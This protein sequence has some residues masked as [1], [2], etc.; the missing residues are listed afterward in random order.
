M[1]IYLDDI[2]TPSDPFW[3]VVRKPAAF[4]ELMLSLKDTSKLEVSFDHDLADDHYEIYHLYE[5]TPVIE[6]VSET[7][8]DLAKWM[9]DNNIIPKTVWVHSANPAGAKNIINLFENR[10]YSNYKG[11]KVIRTFWPC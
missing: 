5:D 8:Y 1:K 3:V 7:G 10:E 4:K 9:I 2:R 6:G 11:P